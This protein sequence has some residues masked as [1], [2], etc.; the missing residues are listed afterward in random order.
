M[1][2][3]RGFIVTAAIVFLVPGGALPRQGIL[4]NP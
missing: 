4:L 1:R 2:F 3:I